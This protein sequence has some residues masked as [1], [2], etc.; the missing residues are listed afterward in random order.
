MASRLAYGNFRFE[1]QP[2]DDIS[3]LVNKILETSSSIDPETLALSNQ[4]RGGENLVSTI[5]GDLQTLGINH[6]DLLFASYQTRSAPS[7]LSTRPQS[8]ATTPQ[9]SSSSSHG[10]TLSGKPV[11]LD[12]SSSSSSNDQPVPSTST[13]KTNVVRV[14]GGKKPWEEVKENPV[15]EYWEKRDGKIAREKGKNGC[16]CGPKSMCD[17]C[18]PLEP[19]DAEYQAS[20]NIKHLSYHSYL[21]KLHAS[22][23]TSAQASTYIPPLADPSYRVSIP[24]A[25]GSHPS[26]PAGICTKCQPSAVTL[27]R[28]TYRMT[29]HVEFATPA[30]IEGLL[31]F[32]RSTGTQRYGYLLGT[33]QPYDKVP[34]GIKAVVEAIH[35]PPQE[36][37]ADGIT[38]G[39][40]W[41]EQSKVEALAQACR[42]LSEG[43]QGLQVL[44]IVFT[45]LTQ[46]T[47]SEESK[48]SGKVLAK[49]H[50]NSFFLSSLE[51]LFSAS[52]QRQYPTPS[53]FSI[54]GKFSS[55]FVTCVVSGDIEGQ[56]SVEAY[57]VSDQAMAMVDAD[58]V[59]P[60]V[61]PGVVRVKEEGPERYIPDVFYRYKNKYGLEV[62]DNAKPCFPVEYLIVNVS[63]GF[64]VSPNPLF[65]S[66][67]P[68]VPEN[69]PGLSDQTLSSVSSTFMSI[70]RSLSSPDLVSGQLNLEGL[71]EEEKTKGLEALVSDEGVMK[72]KNWF[73]DW[74]LLRFLADCGMFEEDDI[75]L[76][77]RLAST[78]ST[79]NSLD[80]LKLLAESLAK[81]FSS[82]NWQT[83]VLVA[84]EQAPLPEKDYPGSSNGGGGEKQM[85][86]GFEIPPDV[87]VPPEAFNNNNNNNQGD[88]PGDNAMAGG[89]GGNAGNDGGAGGAGG[90]GMQICPHCTFENAPGQ[91][92]CDIC[93]LPLSG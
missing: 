34:M 18:M 29:D 23:P 84:Q 12:P 89:A 8:D 67:T 54:D 88:Q 71:P 65:T 14:P 52:L 38:V 11:P 33:Y 4:P 79:S 37:H 39:F 21:K 53:R 64:P 66:P 19:F 74:H 73:S 70:Y 26:W 2:T 90:G 41:E 93:G 50:A 60:S 86:D 3:A 36:P 85:I 63:H 40:P 77:C 45:D 32:W 81:L 58:M 49:R 46:D 92:D 30:L 5:E 78:S 82:P 28:Q 61:D 51:V 25:S 1:L 48:R 76:M 35:E 7:A 80:S 17:Y 62:K 83:F 87:G 13:A 31:S 75:R 9:A 44:G 68:F 10:A 57:Q 56:I 91:Q 72:L 69:R 42:P 6:G 27:S 59:E 24:C 47:S 55:R 20:Q 15:D 43:G 22:I 16:R